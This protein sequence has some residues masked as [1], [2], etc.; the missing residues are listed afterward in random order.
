M[1]RYKSIVETAKAMQTMVT[2]MN[3]ANLKSRKGKDDM[4]TDRA[5]HLWDKAKE[6]AKKQ[7]REDEYAYVMGIFKK[8]TGY[9]KPNKKKKK[10]V[11]KGK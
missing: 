1:K 7:G 4:T 6:I 11:K 9:K 8:M 5:E 10:S 3:T 2:R